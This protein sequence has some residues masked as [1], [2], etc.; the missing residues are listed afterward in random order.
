LCGI[1]FGGVGAVAAERLAEGFILEGETAPWQIR[2][3][4]MSYLE[5]ENLYMAEGG[6]IISRNSQR[7]TAQSAKYNHRTGIVQVTGNVR[8]ETNGDVLT[9]ERGIFDLNNRQ[10]QITGGQLFLRHNHLY[11]RGKVMRQIGPNSYKVMDCRITTCDGEKPDWSISGSEVNVTL[12]GYGTVRHAAFRIKDIPFFYAPYAVFPAKTK[13]QTG[14]LPPRVGYSNLNGVDIEIPFF[15]AASDQTDMTF[16]E[17]LMSERGFMQGAEW[18]YVAEDDSKGALL[19]DILSDKEE[20]KDFSD[21]DQASLSPFPRTNET[22]YWL[23]GRADQRLPGK[24]TARFDA[25]FLSDQD[26]LKEFRSGLFGHEWR[27]DLAEETGRPVEEIQSPTRRSALRLSRDGQSYSLQGLSAYHQ[28]P[29]KPLYDKTPQPLGGLAFSM[30][31]RALPRFPLFF[32]LDTDYNYIWRENGLK[33]SSLSFTPGLSWPIWLGPYLAFEP[34]LSYM[35]NIEWF[36]NHESHERQLEDAYH[37]QVQLSSIVERIYDFEWKKAKRLKHKIMPILTYDFRGHNDEDKSSP[38]FVSIDEAEDINRITL[39][40][41]NFLDARK[42]GREGHVTYSQWATLSLIQAYDINEQRRD[43]EPG[44]EKRPFEPLVGL[45]SLTRFPG[46]DL[47]VEV[48]WDHYEKSIPFADVSLGLSIK[49]SGGR[50]DVYRLGY[51]YS[52]EGYNRDWYSTS[53]YT[54]NWYSTEGYSRAG[55]ENLSYLLNVNLISGFSVGTSLRRNLKLGHDIESRY[56]LDYQ[57][58]CWGI[59]VAAER[60][61]GVQSVAVTFNLLG[62]EKYW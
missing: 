58:Q 18:R 14:F 15:W 6:V 40:L 60:L 36:D 3:G 41:E 45:I 61:E 35:G 53:G 11:I 59:R 24:I 56:W 51:Q 38:W 62:L 52:R 7:L 30:M 8:L 42:E 29:E 26:Y 57:A 32:M 49:R 1:A 16:Y 25:D 13:R 48:H 28:R 43:P 23:R 54:T 10:G 9:G 20:T 19:F 37:F 39:S 2:A 5:K 34:S 50:K 33:G 22:R 44:S 46:P 47:D 17:R 4:S 55:N 27:P 21:E 31:P 12:E